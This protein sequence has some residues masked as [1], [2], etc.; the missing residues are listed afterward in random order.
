MVRQLSRRT[1]LRSRGPRIMRFDFHFTDEGWNISEVNSDVPG[2]FVEGSGFTNLM[3]RHFGTSSPSGAAEAYVDAVHRAANEKG[4]I[5][6]VHATAYS[7]DRQ[8]MEYLARLLRERGRAVMH[9]SPA[10]IDWSKRPAR[11]C[12][13]YSNDQVAAI[14]RFFPADWLSRL[15]EDCSSPFLDGHGLSISNPTTALLVQSKAFPLVWDRLKT[16]LPLWRKLL[17]ETRSARGLKRIERDWVLKPVYGRV[18]EDVGIAEI[19]PQ[20]QLHRL[21]HEAQRNSRDWIL[22]RRFH[23]NAIPSQFGDLYPCIGVYTLDKTA[24]GCY[25]RIAKKPLTDD[26]AQDIAVLF[27][28]ETN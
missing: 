25:A 27:D 19:T 8:V 20:D 15:P 2:G 6:L 4:A 13:A 21:L 9:V 10:Q 17:P 24:V 26:E 1:S 18:G 28:E 16:P 3:A 14:V 7:D 12:A 5:A 23:A 22:Q 11:N